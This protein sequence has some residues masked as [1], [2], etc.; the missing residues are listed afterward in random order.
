M[1]VGIDIPSV[2]ARGKGFGENA[3]S[4]F[5]AYLFNNCSKDILYAKTW[6]EN[7]PMLRLAEKIGFVEI[8]RIS[9]LREVRESK[10]DALTFAIS[11]QDFFS[12]YH[13]LRSV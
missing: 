2:D 9:G 7:K 6:S 8:E 1:A 4:L 11:K 3:L 12:K 10:Y 5:M 13:A